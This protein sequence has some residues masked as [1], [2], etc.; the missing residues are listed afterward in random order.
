MKIKY[1]LVSLFTLGMLS[2]HGRDINTIRQSGILKIG[3]PADYAPLAFKN[4]LGQLVGY[5]IDMAHH[6]GERLQ[7]DIVFIQTSWPTLSKDLAADHFD[8]AMGGVTAT[9]TRSAEFALSSPVVPNGKIALA[10]CS[11]ADK[12]RDLKHIDRPE[13]KIV[14]NPGGTN[15]SFVDHH[16]KQAQI[17]RVKD[18][19][20]NIQAIREHTADMMVTDLIEGNYYQN[21]EPGIFCVATPKV[22]EGTS[23]FK[24]YMVQK[25]NHALLND[26]NQ[27]L[28]EDIKLHLAK[29]WA[30][31]TH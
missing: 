11:V 27:W 1:L 19:F 24:I 30:I 7:L 2:A 10:A 5:D 16:I 26:I 23:S 18:N 28:K 13:I 21:K 9:P 22:F 14:V 8:I 31:D 6:L 25:N 15:Q 4:K 20:A 12:L 17:I 3:V 29:K